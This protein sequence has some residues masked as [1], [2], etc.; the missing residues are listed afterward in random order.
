MYKVLSTQGTIY[1]TELPEV[2][3]VER[4]SNKSMIYFSYHCL[5]V[6]CLTILISIHSWK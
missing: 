2:V 6:Y 3:I 1:D 5:I 4:T